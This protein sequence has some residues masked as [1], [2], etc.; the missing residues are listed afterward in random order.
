MILSFIQG[1][2][3]TLT[4]KDAPFTNSAGALIDPTTVKFTYWVNDANP[5]VLTYGVDVGLIRVSTGV[6]EYDLDTTPIPVGSTV[7]A[8]AWSTGVGQAQS[9]PPVKFDV[10]GVP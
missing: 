5:V 3:V 1:E 7:T 4:T 10:N 8:Q 6:Y 9:N 2:E